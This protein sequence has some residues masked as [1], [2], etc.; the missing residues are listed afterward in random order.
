MR[1]L[2]PTVQREMMRVTS[3][4]MSAAVSSWN[5]IICVPWSCTLW[6]YIVN[7]SYICTSE[8]NLGL[9]LS[10]A[11]MQPFFLTSGGGGFCLFFKTS[12][13]LLFLFV[14]GGY[15]LCSIVLVSAIHQHE[16]AIGI[17]MSPPS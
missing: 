9:K 1:R 5:C 17:H 8:L 7:K 11:N 13:F 4:S 12:G 3:I 2:E 10:F 15:L 16:S 6:P 14:I